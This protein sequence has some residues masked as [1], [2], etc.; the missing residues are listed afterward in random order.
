MDKTIIIWEYDT[1]LN[2]WLEKVRF[3]KVGGNNIGFRGALFSPN[4]TNESD[5]W[6]PGLPMSGHY[7]SVQDIDWDPDGEFLLSCSSDQ[8]TRLHAPVIVGLKNNWFEIARPQI[9][10][11]DMVCLT[12]LDRFKFVSAGDE[13]VIRVFEAPRSFAEN[14]E[15]LTKL[16][17]SS[18]LKEK[19]PEGA[20]V[21]SQG[22]S[23]KAVF[24]EDIIKNVAIKEQESRKHPKDRYPEFSYSPMTLTAPPT[25]ET[26]LQNTLWPETQKLY[27]HPYEVFTIASNHAGT[28]VA[29]ACKRIILWSRST[30]RQ[31]ATLAFHS[32]TVTQI[33]FSPD[34]QYLLSVSRD[35]M[36][37]LYRHFPDKPEIY[38]KVANLDRKSGIHT[39]IIWSC[40]W[41]FDSLYFA[42]SSRDKKVAM[43]RKNEDNSTEFSLSSKPLQVEDSATAVSIAPCFV[44]NKYLIAIGLENGSIILSLFCSENSW[45][46]LQ[47]LDKNIAHYLNVNRLKFS[48]VPGEAGSRPRSSDVLQLASCSNDNHTKIYNIF[49]GML[50]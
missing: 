23:N 42:T 1:S 20:S 36:W 16:N 12:V 44:K 30:W 47:K 45:E 6:V 31:V 3:G 10:G 18:Y 32:L 9:H 4:G 37:A 29:S 14:L 13:K 11:Y 24:S 5:S 34:D 2:M 41:S 28:L 26:L 48:P 8:T 21:P 50:K 15:K 38:K 35:R 7:S 19:M 40:S 22:L 27:G 49:I 39:R 25:E 33:A 17:V 43:W 46:I